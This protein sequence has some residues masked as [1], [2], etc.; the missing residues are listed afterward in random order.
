MILITGSTGNVGTPLL[1]ILL[2]AGVEVR[3]LVRDPASEAEQVKFMRAN[4]IEVVGGDLN[5]YESLVDAVAGI[6]A[7]FLL[8]PVS[9]EQVSWKSNL[10]RA[11][12][13]A[14]VKR[15]VNLSV[16]GAAPDSPLILGRWHWESE[17]ELEASGIA[18]THLRPYDLAQYNTKLFLMTAR[19]QGAFYSTVGDGRVAMVDE[20]DVAA[21]AAQALMNPDH[22]GKTYTLT[23]PRALSYPQIADAISQTIGKPVRYVNITETEAKVAMLGMGM[24]EWIVDFINDLRQLESKGGAEAVSSDVEHVTG[25]T[26]TA[27]ATSL[28]AALVN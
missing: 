26:A 22:V 20:E 12:H 15:I 8:T 11:A 17:Q 10:I 9:R 16:A 4:G 1:R 14:A 19:D 6:E 25:K 28:Q 24:P 5:D 7:A 13:Q 2:Q 27:Y 3:A 18:W 23:G 21:V